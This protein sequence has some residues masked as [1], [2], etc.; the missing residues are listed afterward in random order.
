MEI[1]RLFYDS[2]DVKPVTLLNHFLSYLGFY[3]EEITEATKP[4]KISSVADIYII[5][6]NYMKCRQ[7]NLTIEPNSKTILIC[8][9]SWTVNTKCHYSIQYKKSN[10][11]DE[12]FLLTLVSYLVSI[13]HPCKLLMHSVSNLNS[14]LKCIIKAYCKFRILPSMLYTHQFYKQRDLYKI[15]LDNYRSFIGALDSLEVSDRDN[16]LVVF[17]RTCAKFEID[18][19]CEK[20]SIIFCYPVEELNST[21]LQLLNRYPENER[22]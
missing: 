5:S 8:K 2:L 18:S 6:N 22:I 1:I 9:D 4:S 17:I 7:N 19:I 16:D 10:E 21:C 11:Q 3:V 15:A 20:N 12:D 13:P 14:V